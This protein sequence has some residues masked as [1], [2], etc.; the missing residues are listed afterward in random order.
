MLRMML[1]LGGLAHFALLPISLAVPR[2]LNWKEELACLRPFLRRLVWTYGAFIVLANL[3][4][5]V[6][7]LV[8]VDDIVNG[9]RAGIAFAA[10]VAIY[11]TVRLG[12]QY[13]YFDWSDFPQ[14]A[15]HKGARYL[16]DLLFLYLVVVYGYAAVHGVLHGR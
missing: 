12:V 8:G 7:T 14:G 16:L 5:G 3:G 11:W 15:V 6:V 4:F 13:A 2:V 1:I 9:T 10:F